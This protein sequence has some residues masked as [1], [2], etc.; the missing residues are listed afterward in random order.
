MHMHIYLLFAA[1]SAATYGAAFFVRRQRW[2][3]RRLAGQRRLL[4]RWRRRR[5]LRFYNGG[6][7]YK[8]GVGGDYY[9]KGGGGSDYYHKGDGCDEGGGDYYY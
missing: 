8:G 2:R 9:Y 7:D 1:V 5:V 6:D 3:L 4:Q